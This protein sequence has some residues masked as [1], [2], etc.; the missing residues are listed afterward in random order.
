MKISTLIAELLRDIVLYVCVPVAMVVVFML[1][2]HGAPNAT[3]NQEVEHEV[4]S[5]CIVADV[6][7]PTVVLEDETGQLW[8]YNCT[9]DLPGVG[10]R[11][12]II[13]AYPCT[14]TALDEASV[15]CVLMDR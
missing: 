12:T 5:N 4:L 2:L 1:V 7:G 9:G 11:A 15:C 13:I 14:D 3:N 10:E 6:C 8:N